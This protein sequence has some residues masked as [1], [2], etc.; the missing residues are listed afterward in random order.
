MPRAIDFRQIQITHDPARRITH[1]VPRTPDFL[2][3]LIGGALALAQQI[4]DALINGF[5]GW[6][7][8][9]FSVDTLATMMNAVGAGLG[10]L[11]HVGMRVAA[12]EGQ[13]VDAITNFAEAAGQALDPNKWLQVLTGT[14][15]GAVTVGQQGYAV[16][17][18]VADTVNKV[19]MVINKT[20]ATSDL[21]KVQAVFSVPAAM[22]AQAANTLLARVDAVD[23]TANHVFAKMTDTTATIGYVAGGVTTVLGTVENT[24]KNGST[25]AL[26]VTE[27]R[28][29]KLVENSRTILT[30]VDAAAQSALGAAFRGTGFGT[31]APN[32]KSR[33]GVVGAFASFIK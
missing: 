22:G 12:L 14:G 8:T 24:L 32:S 17:Q 5:H 20:V 28:T 2:P 15:G 31:V 18:P 29:F 3:P 33:P 10:E 25:Y 21:Q 9:G 1:E 13:V 16:F 23:P 26:D 4:I 19:A 7:D 30:A 27:P 11:N 6:F